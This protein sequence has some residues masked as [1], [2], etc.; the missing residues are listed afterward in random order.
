[1][2]AFGGKADMVGHPDSQPNRTSESR[3]NIETGRCFRLSNGDEALPQTGLI[4]SMT[5]MGSVIGGVAIGW[6]G[7]AIGRKNALPASLALL[8]AGS[9]LSAFAWAV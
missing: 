1:M 2:P 4:V 6:L 7:D 5:L 3:P 8:A 9:V